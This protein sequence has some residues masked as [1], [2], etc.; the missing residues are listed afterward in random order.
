[1]NRR[2]VLIGIGTAA[3]GSGVVFG[4]GAFTQL[5]ADRSVSIGVTADDNGDTQ[6]QLQASA[7]GID[8]SGGDSSNELQISDTNANPNATVQF[9]SVSGGDFSSISPSEVTAGFT[10]DN[11][12]G[13]NL[14][15][16]IFN[17]PDSEVENDESLT[18]AADDTNSATSIAS[19]SDSGAT[20]DGI[21]TTDTINV[22]VEAVT[23]SDTTA[24]SSTIRIEATQP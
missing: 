21:G 6:V 7:D 15:I 22:A 24:L 2:N 1:M 9:G 17:D 8:T 10:I 16:T 19:G 23:D 11:N 5:Q 12:S 20:F 14:D 18:L 13:S 4:S 3:A